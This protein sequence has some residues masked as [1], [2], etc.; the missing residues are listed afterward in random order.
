MLMVCWLDGLVHFWGTG[1][2][3]L[4]VFVFCL[5]CVGVVFVWVFL[6]PYLGGSPLIGSPA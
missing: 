6:E 1:A 5:D 4:G 3:F 2:V